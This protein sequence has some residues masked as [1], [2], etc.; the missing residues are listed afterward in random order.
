MNDSR[1]IALSC[2]VSKYLSL[3]ELPKHVYQVFGPICNKNSCRTQL[4]E[5]Q[6]ILYTYLSCNNLD[7]FPHLTAL[8]ARNLSNRKPFN[9]PI[10][11]EIPRPKS[12]VNVSG[13]FC[14][15]K[16]KSIINISVDYRDFLKYSD[17]YA[18]KLH[19]ARQNMG[20]SGS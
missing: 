9:R 19:F 13:D 1:Q 4:K 12:E 5:Q 3:L 20:H 7:Q 2:L 15:R 6:K 17:F 14:S 8:F 18:E 11:S 16:R 10:A